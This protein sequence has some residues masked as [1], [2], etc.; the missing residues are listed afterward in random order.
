MTSPDSL[1]AKILASMNRAPAAAP[2]TFAD[3]IAVLERDDIPIVDRDPERQT[4]KVR[5]EDEDAKVEVYVRL[6]DSDHG[7][8]IT[9]GQAAFATFPVRNFG[10]A[11][12]LA[13]LAN[14]ELAEGKEEL[15]ADFE[16]DFSDARSIYSSVSV[17]V[18]GVDFGDG[19]TFS[20]GVQGSLPYRGRESL[21]G[22]AL[23]FGTMYGANLVLMDEYEEGHYDRLGG[24]LN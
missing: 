9:M 24:T 19:G 15:C 10:D 22:L 6:V 13:A 1:R 14:K 5:Y 18:S 17:G 2:C 3:I 23:L 4:V 16:A 20:I 8:V 7:Q 12:R 21:D 11:A